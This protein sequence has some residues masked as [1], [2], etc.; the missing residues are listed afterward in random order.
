MKRGEEFCLEIVTLM[1]QIHWFPPFWGSVFK[2][3]N[4][5]CFHAACFPNILNRS[6]P[7]PH[8]EFKPA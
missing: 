6:D 2:G 5:T 7:S 8:T 4:F 1:F 3:K